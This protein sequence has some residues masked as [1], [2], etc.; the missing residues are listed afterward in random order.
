MIPF[1]QQHAVVFTGAFGSGKTEV[2]DQ[3]RGGRW[4]ERA[5][6]SA[7]WTATS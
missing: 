2:R 4:Q 7:C 6:P 3:L 5:V 1:S